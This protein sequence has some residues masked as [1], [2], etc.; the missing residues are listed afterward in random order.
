MQWELH[1]QRSLRASCH[2][3]YNIIM[4]NV[5][6]SKNIETHLNLKMSNIS[7][8]S[9]NDK[10]KTGYKNMEV[11]CRQLWSQ[12]QC[13]YCNYAAWPG[14]FLFKMLVSSSQTSASAFSLTVNWFFLFSSRK[15]KTTF[16][17]TGEDETFH[18]TFTA[19]IIDWSSAVTA[20]SVQ[21]LD[22]SFQNK[23]GWW[24]KETAC[25]LD[26]QHYRCV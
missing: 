20:P 25:H 17:Y 9:S 2:L 15:E 10:I 23:A 3:W 6:A 14:L 19:E 4:A 7:W 11:N 13:D 21:L 12:L 22:W 5:S 8:C 16:L 1:P 24:L 18:S 26:T